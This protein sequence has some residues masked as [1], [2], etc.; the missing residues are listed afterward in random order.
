MTSMFKLK[1]VKHNE[2][3]EKTKCRTRITQAIDECNIVE[4]KNR[5]IALFVLYCKL[6]KYDYII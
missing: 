5:R 4:E 1:S 6:V 3:S 2:A